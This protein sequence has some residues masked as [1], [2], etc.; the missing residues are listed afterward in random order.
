MLSDNIKNLRKQKGYSQETLAEELNVVR[1]TVSKW[2]KNY[3]VPDA[4][5]LEKIADIFEVSVSDLLGNSN[6]VVEQKTDLEKIAAQLAILNDQLARELGRKKRRRIRRRIY[7][8]V[9]MITVLL[10][11]IVGIFVFIPLPFNHAN[12]RLHGDASNVMITPEE[13]EI[14]TDEQIDE[15]IDIV[16][17]DFE[18]S[19]KGC[20]LTEIRYGGDE[21]ARVESECRGVETIVLLSTI[22][23]DRNAYGS[24]FNTNETYPDYQWILTKD[25][26]GNWVHIDNGYA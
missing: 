4:L 20:T 8:V 26:N 5:M 22:E 2:E 9:A 3:S 10:A 17:V 23:T 18:K 15:A 11:M 1:Q 25:D 19:W 7:L 14:Y 21:V 13:S 12:T 16:R 6:K 24:G